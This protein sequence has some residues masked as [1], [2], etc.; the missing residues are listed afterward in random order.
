MEYLENSKSLKSKRC[1]WILVWPYTKGPVTSFLTFFSNIMNYANNA[2]ICLYDLKAENLFSRKT[3]AYSTLNLQFRAETMLMCVWVVPHLHGISAFLLPWLACSS[4]ALCTEASA[5]LDA[6]WALVQTEVR[7]HRSIWLE[8]GEVALT[9]K[10]QL[11]PYS[12]LEPE[13]SGLKKKKKR[14]LS[15]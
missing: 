6:A 15:P 1:Q 8:W 3:T 7:R 4:S 2:R 5:C 13:T 10:P 11:E 14:D 12:L 9:M